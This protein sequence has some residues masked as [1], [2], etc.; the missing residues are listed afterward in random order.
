MVIFKGLTLLKT[1]NGL[2]QAAWHSTQTVQ[3]FE[4]FITAPCSGVGRLYTE[5]I[6]H[7]VELASSLLTSF[8]FLSFF[9]SDKLLHTSLFSSVFIHC[10]KPFWPLSNA[11]KVLSWLKLPLLHIHVKTCKKLYLLLTTCTQDTCCVYT[12]VVWSVTCAHTSRGAI[13]MG[14]INK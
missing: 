10:S 14:A 13:T 9:L 1:S 4:E 5:I 12:A 7:Y 3:P 2:D 6:T 11:Y 8:R